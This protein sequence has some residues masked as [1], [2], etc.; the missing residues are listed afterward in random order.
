MLSLLNEKIRKSKSV[1]QANKSNL[2]GIREAMNL[3]VKIVLYREVSFG[4]V[5]A[6]LYFFSSS[7]V[8][9]GFLTVQ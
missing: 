1:H 7:L 6:N 5:K 2:G 8:F 3:N 9:I 4:L